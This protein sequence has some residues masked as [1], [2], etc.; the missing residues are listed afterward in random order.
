MFQGFT[1][2]PSYFPQTLKADLDEIKFPQKLYF[3]T[4]CRQSA[5]LLCFP[6][7]FTGRQHTY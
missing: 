1:E 3:M 2:N 4:M 6:G 5:S 7:L